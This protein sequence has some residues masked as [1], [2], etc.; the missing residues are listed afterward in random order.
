M[1]NPLTL[2]LSPLLV[3]RVKF[4]VAASATVMAFGFAAAIV[5]GV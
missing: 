3:Q 2:F 4:V 1:V 5:F